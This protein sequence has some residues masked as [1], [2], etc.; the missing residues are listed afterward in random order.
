MIIAALLLSMAPHAR[1][2]SRLLPLTQDST[3]TD[4]I[5]APTA[6][7]TCTLSTT[8]TVQ[9]TNQS[10]ATALI[11]SPASN[12]VLV[13]PTNVLPGTTVDVLSIDNY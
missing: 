7:V 1:A 5:L 3:L 2:A 11:L 10:F 12:L 9:S 8:S 4:L 13:P 6:G